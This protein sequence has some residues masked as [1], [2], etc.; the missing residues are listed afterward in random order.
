MPSWLIFARFAALARQLTSSLNA[1]NPQ[2]PPQS[3]EPY[4]ARRTRLDLSSKAIAAKWIVEMRGV[5]N[6]PH[7]RVSQTCV[8]HIE[9]GFSSGCWFQ[10][11]LKIDCM[12]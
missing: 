9:G 12:I 8:D 4:A 7:F 10:P 5:P 11:K 6:P 1:A 3:R 2:R